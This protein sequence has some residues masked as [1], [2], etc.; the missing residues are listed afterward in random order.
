MRGPH[1]GGHEHLVAVD[2]GGTQSL[3]YLAFVLVDLG[4]VDMAIAE[5]QRL[6]D[7]SRA[8]AAAQLPGAEPDCRNSC[9]VGLNE[10]HR[11][12]PYRWDSLALRCAAC[13]CGKHRFRR[14]RDDGEK[15]PRGSP[16]HAL[17]LLPVTDGFDGHPEPGGEFGLG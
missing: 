6:L 1:L 7:H 5:P 17:A 4:A 16:R 10:L 8:G 11:G 12:F 3:A 14:V 13:E 15:R 9:A 2:A